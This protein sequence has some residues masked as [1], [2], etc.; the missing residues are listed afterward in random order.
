M[1]EN[2][3][4]EL[5]L[6]YHGEKTD[7]K[8]ARAYVESFPTLAIKTLD[9]ARENV[10]ETQ[11]AQIA[12][13]MQVAIGA[14]VDITYDDRSSLVNGSESIKQMDNGELLTLIRHNPK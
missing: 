2:E 4:R 11:L 9:L 7:D 13:K 5:T 3:P 1:I 8:K 6:I 14:L 10:T 12:D